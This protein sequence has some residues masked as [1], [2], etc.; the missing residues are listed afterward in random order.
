MLVLYSSW[1]FDKTDMMSNSPFM[2]SRSRHRYFCI[3][4]I[5]FS[6]ALS[7]FAIE[8]RNGKLKM[9][10]YNVEYALVVTGICSFSTP[11]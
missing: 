7:V 8:Q 2:Y 10:S 6:W 1:L 11:A 9:L 3:L 4:Y 5:T